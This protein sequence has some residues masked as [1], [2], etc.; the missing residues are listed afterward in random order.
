[1]KFTVLWDVAQC[2]HVEVDRHFTG[3]TSQ[4]TINFKIVIISML[5]LSVIE[6]VLSSIDSVY[7]SNDS[8]CRPTKYLC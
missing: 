6:N 3:A 2:S 5:F 8:Y 4:K 7:L 1:M